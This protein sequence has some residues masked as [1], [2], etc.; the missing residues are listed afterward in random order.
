MK[1]YNKIIGNYGED[2]CEEYLLRHGH[3]IL[4]RNFRCKL[5]ELDIISKIK[6]LNCICFIEVKSR[7]HTRYGRPCESI[8]YKKI[9]KIKNTA[10][11][12]IMKNNLKD[13]NFRFDVMEVLFNVEKDDYTLNL[14]KNAF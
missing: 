8:S 10:Q 1:R 5:G 3:Q 6:D 4:H 14:I 2:I 11:F 13:V 7:Y 9:L 12:Y